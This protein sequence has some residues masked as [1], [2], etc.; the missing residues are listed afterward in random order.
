[1]WECECISTPNRSKG[2][3]KKYLVRGFATLRVCQ[4]FSWGMEFNFY[5]PL[6]KTLM[7]RDQ[8]IPDLMLILCN[9]HEHLY[10]LL[11][12]THFPANRK[13][14]TNS[15]ISI[16][17]VKSQWTHSQRYWLWQRVTV[18]FNY[19]NLL[20]CMCLS[21]ALYFFSFI[22]PVCSGFSRLFIMI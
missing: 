7:D 10:S 2:N 19:F 4:R 16:W 17:L 8:I 11:C 3:W 1:M 18:Y 5:W 6:V 22:P 21:A 20:D 13:S 12:Q 14:S 9:Y 15:H